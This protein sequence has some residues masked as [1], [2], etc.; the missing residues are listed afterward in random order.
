MFVTTNSSFWVESYVSD[1]SDT[2]WRA[3]ELSCRLKGLLGLEIIDQRGE[4]GSSSKLI[5]GAFSRSLRPEKSSFRLLS[6]S[7]FLAFLRCSE[8]TLVLGSSYFRRCQILCYSLLVSL[9]F[10][11]A[12]VCKSLQVLNLPSVCL[13]MNLLTFVIS[14]IW[15]TFKRSSSCCT[16]SLSSSSFLYQASS[17]L[18]SMTSK[19][20]FLCCSTAFLICSSRFKTLYH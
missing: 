16:A 19:W 3:N 4:E 6:K 2:T 1:A 12:F 11:I 17:T 9:N 20:S 7:A 10:V 14:S 18:G 13:L 8:K 15:F 5:F